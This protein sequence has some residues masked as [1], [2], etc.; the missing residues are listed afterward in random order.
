[1]TPG[2]N[3]SNP[4]VL[5]LGLLLLIVLAGLVL[6]GGAVSSVELN[7]PDPSGPP[8]EPPAASSPESRTAGSNPPP[9]ATAPAAVPE[10][11]G[12][13]S[14]A[15]APS[16]SPAPEYRVEVSLAEQ[17]VR[18]YRDGQLIREMIAST[19][20]PDQPTPTGRFRLQ[21]RGEWFYSE[22][23]QQG[24]RWW[25]SFQGWGRY[26]FHSVPMDAKQ[27]IIPEEAAKL[28]QPASHGCVRLS[29]EDARWF[30]ETL[31]EGTPVEIH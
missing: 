13:S 21:N 11:S 15:S 14:S 28:G 26:L 2:K 23:Y 25:V 6:T 17:R 10:A 19:G 8:S 9:A 1:M 4:A 27:Q 18:I 24:A 16:T 12:P 20:T 31:P 7:R 5:L 22:K 29:L 30:Y 3:P